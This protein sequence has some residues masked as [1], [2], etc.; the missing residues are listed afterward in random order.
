MV[1]ELITNTTAFDRW[2]VP[3]QILPMVLVVYGIEHKIVLLLVYLWETL[4]VLFMSCLQLFEEEDITNSIIS[5][6]LQG[7]I[8]IIMGLL[9]LKRYDKI[10]NNVNLNI[11]TLI[12]FA[13]FCSVGVTLFDFFYDRNLHWLYIPV[14][15]IVTIVVLKLNNK[16]WYDGVPIYV[17]CI[18]LTS[19]TFI[20]QDIVSSFYVGVIHG[21]V[22]S[23]SLILLV[24]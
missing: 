10:N 5:D 1:C 7:F 19:I 12:D 6:P 18:S 13:L 17:L 4:E 14:L 21:I 3:H 15:C 11:N 16:K 22:I 9:I 2:V 20:L 23:F 24:T 8:G